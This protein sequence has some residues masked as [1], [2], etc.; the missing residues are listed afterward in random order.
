[1]SITLKASTGY[2]A[3]WIV[4]D[5]LPGE[6]RDEILACFG[7]TEDTEISGG[8]VADL[9]LAQLTVYAASLFATYYSQGVGGQAGGSPWKGRS[10][11]TTASQGKGKAKPAEASEKPAETPSEDDIQKGILDLIE[12]ATTKDELKAV[13]RDHGDNI[14]ADETLRDALKA[15]NA[16][17]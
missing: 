5:G 14:K 10:G 13:V 7:L 4:F 11:A 2:D 8:K 16:A 12:N 15:R 3:P 17:L 9:S 1:M 6:Q